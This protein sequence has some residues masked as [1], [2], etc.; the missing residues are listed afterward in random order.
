MDHLAYRLNQDTP[1]THDQAENLRP[2]NI[3]ADNARANALTVD[4]EDY[5]QVEAFKGVI[6]N[7]SW[8]NIP[9]RVE[10]NTQRL[11]D[12]FAQADIKATFFVLGW[13]AER[14]PEIVRR[15]HAAG[16]EV[17]SHGYAHQ[18][19]HLQSRDIFRDDIQRSKRLLEDISGERVK[20]YRAPTFSV[21]RSNWWAYDVLAEEGYDYSSSLYPVSHD[22][23][24]TPDAPIAP[25]HPTE[26]GLLE[27][28]LSTMKIG[29]RNL[30]CSGGGY[31]RLLPYAVSQWCIERSLAQRRS[32][33]VFYC[34]P[35]EFDAG[36]PRIQA[37]AKSRF[38]HYTNIARMQGR[39]A[40]LFEDFRWNRMDHVFARE[41]D[42]VAAA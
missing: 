16:H 12:M 15:I 31:F 21:R 18:L 2:Q 5:F 29:G 42:K 37:G 9:T 22:L 33:F 7:D 4:V 30:P 19:A 17:G 27:I 13:V 34:H 3:L 39:V 32:P 25:F 10:A 20:G 40:R 28:P 26:S 38:R 6:S 8:D 14:H 11:L 1:D 41:L 35:W 36:Q 24:G 23:Y